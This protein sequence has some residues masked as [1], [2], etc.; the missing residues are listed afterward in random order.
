[1]LNKRLLNFL[2]NVKHT[3]VDDVKILMMSPLCF[4]FTSQKVNSAA[5]AFA[6]AK[7]LT[8]MPAE[9]S[10]YGEPQI[11]GL[12][13]QKSVRISTA[14]TA[15]NTVLFLPLSHRHGITPGIPV[16]LNRQSYGLP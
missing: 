1:M 7:P 8:M 2:L 12:T 5:V 4:M 6:A 16:T 15:W 13:G 3:V 14:S 9:G 10:A 11:S